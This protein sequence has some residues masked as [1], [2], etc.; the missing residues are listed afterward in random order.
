MFYS[1]VAANG[2]NL[3]QIVDT[4]QHSVCVSAVDTKTIAVSVANSTM[5]AIACMRVRARVV[6]ISVPQLHSAAHPTSTKN[7]QKKNHSNTE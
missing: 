1:I 7:G 5:C 6:C 4:I 3:L 2:V